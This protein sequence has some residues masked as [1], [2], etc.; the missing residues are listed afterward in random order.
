MDSNAT[1]TSEDPPPSP[2]VIA[3]QAKIARLQDQ[4]QAL[5]SDRAALISTATLPS[6]LA[7]PSSW[8]EETRAKTALEAAN[9]LIKD[10]ITALHRY[11]EAKDVAQ[12]L[13]GM[14]AEKRGVRVADVMEDFGV[15]GGD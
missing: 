1:G 12:G 6:G 7:I 4:L 3:L 8:D 13:M 10:H 14:I 11:N 2:R 9:A 5:Q 15:G